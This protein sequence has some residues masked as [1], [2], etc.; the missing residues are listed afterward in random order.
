M[1]KALLDH[2]QEKAPQVSDGLILVLC[3]ALSE[4]GRCIVYSG[5]W[6]I[7]FQTGTYKDLSLIRAQR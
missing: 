7:D 5:T 3:L 2:A 4:L 1:V 6:A